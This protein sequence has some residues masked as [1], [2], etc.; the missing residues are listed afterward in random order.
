VSPDILGNFDNVT[1]NGHCRSRMRTS[2][3]GKNLLLGTQ[4]RSN[5]GDY[6]T[7]WLTASIDTC[8]ACDQR[9]HVGSST[10]PT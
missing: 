4:I 7:I 10:N 5:R 3:E 1:I 6:V 8:N 9:R 2:S